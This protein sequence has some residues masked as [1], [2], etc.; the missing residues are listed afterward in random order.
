MCLQ[1]IKESKDVWRVVPQHQHQG[2]TMGPRHIHG[3]R[4]ALLHGHRSQDRPAVFCNSGGGSRDCGELQVEG[5]ET[6][7]ME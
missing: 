7:R 5:Q 2:A 1:V 3:A 6:K 4:Q